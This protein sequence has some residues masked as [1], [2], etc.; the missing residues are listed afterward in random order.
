MTEVI[1]GVADGPDGS[2]ATIDASGRVWSWSGF[3]RLRSAFNVEF[4]ATLGVTH[5]RLAIVSPGSA[6]SQIIVGSWS[7]GVAAFT[8]DGDLLWRRRDIR[9]VHRLVSMPTGAPNRQSRV[10]VVCERGSCLVLGATGGTR[11]QLV[12]GKFLAGGPDGSVLLHKRTEVQRRPQPDQEP[13]WRVVLGT[14]AVLDA[15]LDEDA[16]VCGADG[17]LRLIDAS[18]QERWR[19]PPDPIQSIVRV[20][21]DPDGSG[22]L[23]VATAIGGRP[24]PAQLLRMR[25]DGN[26]EPIAQITQACVGFVD[27]GR[28]YVT[29]DGSVLSAPAWRDPQPLDADLIS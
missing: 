7:H 22:W 6:G 29:S 23:C 10:G 13:L 2:F 26:A 27:G 21:P 4:A 8:V 20:T 12:G 28:R 15:V 24:R 17:R 16:L 14:F 25:R 18:G 9:S 19:T 5:H 11:Y 3:E 1:T